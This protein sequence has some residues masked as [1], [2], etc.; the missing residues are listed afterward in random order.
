[1]C[2]SFTPLDLAFEEFRPEATAL[3]VMAENVVDFDEY[4]GGDYD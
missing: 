4:L 3:A 2:D 1:L